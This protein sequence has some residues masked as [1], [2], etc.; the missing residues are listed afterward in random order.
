M[1][2]RPR[3]IGVCVCACVQR[4]A[5]GS[6]LPSGLSVQSSAAVFC[7]TQTGDLVLLDGELVVIG[8]LLINADGLL[9]IDHNLFL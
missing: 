5:L 4:Q 6:V 2:T 9:R 8:D 1:L 3:G 7:P